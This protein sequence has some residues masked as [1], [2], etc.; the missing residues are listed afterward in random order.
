MEVDFAGNIVLTA[1]ID[2]SDKALPPIISGNHDLAI[3]YPATETWKMIKTACHNLNLRIARSGQIWTTG[4][5]GRICTYDPPNYQEKI[6]YTEKSMAY[7]TFVYGLTVTK[8]DVFI[9]SQPYSDKLVIIDSRSEKPR[10]VA[11]S[12]PALLPGN[13]DHD[14]NGDA[15]VAFGNGYIGKY[16]LDKNKWKFWKVPSPESEFG[17]TDVPFS[18]VVDRHGLLGPQD[19]VYIPMVNSDSI[20]S[21]N[22]KSEKFQ[23][24]YVPVK[25]FYVREAELSKGAIWAPFA[26]DP[27]R[28]VE[29]TQ[30]GGAF[31]PRVVQ[32]KL[33]N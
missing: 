18:V 27:S 4:T 20:L 10:K 25:G 15:W 1:N 24:F 16:G 22:E 3:F 8:K 23:R 32:I 30:F 26:G 28:L 21:F 7:E 17:A 6:H 12:G 5:S 33:T 2:N 13:L 19:N 29:E 11:I 9:A 31:L 14:S